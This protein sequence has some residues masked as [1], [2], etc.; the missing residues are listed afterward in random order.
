MFA[1]LVLVLV[2][3][4]IDGISLLR[5]C[6]YQNPEASPFSTPWHPLLLTYP[7][8]FIVHTYIVKIMEYKLGE[9]VFSCCQLLGHKVLVYRGRRLS[10]YIL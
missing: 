10:T 8:T 3:F 4:D 9:V 2:L 7:H 1:L 6:A 5:S